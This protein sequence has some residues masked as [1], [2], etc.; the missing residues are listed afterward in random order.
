MPIQEAETI[1]DEYARDYYNEDMKHELI[2]LL[3]DTE[4]LSEDQINE[5]ELA[6]YCHLYQVSMN[7][8]HII[9]EWLEASED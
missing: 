7:T 6:V 1:V 3:K 4:A 2:S 8:Y 9:D 5:I